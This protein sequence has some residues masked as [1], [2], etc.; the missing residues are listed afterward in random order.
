MDKNI[1][2][3]VEK[4]HHF[5]N[6]DQSSKGLDTIRTQ[7]AQLNDYPKETTD[8]TSLHHFLQNDESYASAP[9]QIEEEKI[10]LNEKMENPAPSESIE[11]VKELINTYQSPSN[12]LTNINDLRHEYYADILRNSK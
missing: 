5:G 2:H 11:K 7:E 6:M 3:S 10:A 4:G 8:F 9:I 12:F 1:P